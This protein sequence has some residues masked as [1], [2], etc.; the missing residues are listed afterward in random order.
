MTELQEIIDWGPTLAFALAIMFII[1][2]VTVVYIFVRKDTKLLAVISAV[3]Y[4]YA[5]CNLV[6]FFVV[7]QVLNLYDYTGH[8]L[9]QVSY[10]SINEQLF[11]ALRIS[12]YECRVKFI[13]EMS[14]LI[15]SKSD[16]LSSFL[17]FVHTTFGGFD[18]DY[19]SGA[20]E[21]LTGSDCSS[22]YTRC[23]YSPLNKTFP[24][25]LEKF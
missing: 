23:T 15:T 5:T 11:R 22:V 20:L 8:L 4:F 24:F 18:G 19:I 3:L 25:L 21:G 7:W 2:V 10:H 14:R 1:N 17:R 16:A 12:S 9:N 13:C 6:V